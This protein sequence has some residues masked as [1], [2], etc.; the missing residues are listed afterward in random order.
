[1]DRLGSRQLDQF[2][3][4]G[5]VAPLDVL[6]PERAMVLLDAIDDYLAAEAVLDTFDLTDPILI[7]EV[8]GDD[9]GKRFEYAD[10]PNPAPT[11][12]PFFFNIWRHDDRFREVAFDPGPAV[13]AKQLLGA[14]EVLLMEDN[15]VVKE[16][17]TGPVPFHQDYSY[18][19]LDR[20]FA[21][22]LWIALGDMDA[23]RGS[24]QIVPRSHLLGERLPVSFGDGRSLMAEHWPHATEVPTAP[25]ADGHELHSYEFTSGQGGFHDAMVWHGSTPNTSDLRRSAYVIRYVVAGSIWQGGVRMPYDDID[26]APGEPLTESHFPRVA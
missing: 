21:V 1:M 6:S 25:D 9:G 5:Y 20:P 16:P 26:C 3:D 4:L 12:F 11:V 14:D 17:H 10:V 2:R 8:V 13:V 22:M 19:P 15:I 7:R 23:A 18:W 24:M